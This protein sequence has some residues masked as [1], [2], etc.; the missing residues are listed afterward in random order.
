MDSTLS[1]Q[2]QLQTTPEPCLDCEREQAE[3]AKKALSFTEDRDTSSICKEITVDPEGFVLPAP[4]LSHP[5]KHSTFKCC[6]LTSLSILFFLLGV[7]VTYALRASDLEMYSICSFSKI[8]GEV[9]IGDNHVVFK[10]PMNILRLGTYIVFRPDTCSRSYSSNLSRSNYNYGTND[11][12]QLEA[13]SELIAVH[14][15]TLNGWNSLAGRMQLI[16][17][18]PGYA[19][20]IAFDGQLLDCCVVEATTRK[21]SE[22]ISKHFANEEE[23]GDLMWKIK[24]FAWK[25]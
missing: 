2:G 24:M 19:I 25:N 1:N 20:G 6:L 14:H 4:T 16:P 23:E 13:N 11:M 7:L 10:K 9:L 21:V 5:G 12:A 8:Q 22:E 18:K 17:L 3:A 15:Y